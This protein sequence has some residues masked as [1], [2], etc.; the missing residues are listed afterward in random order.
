[1]PLLLLAGPG[2]RYGLDHAGV[3]ARLEALVTTPAPAGTIERL[4]RWPDP[5]EPGRFVARCSCRAWSAVGT[6]VE[7]NAA[8][9]N[10][11]DSPFRHHVVS[12]YGKVRDDAAVVT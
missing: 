6:V 5:D 2:G 9:R 10:H 11:D 12:I 3:R 8:G 1:V 4:G 7:V